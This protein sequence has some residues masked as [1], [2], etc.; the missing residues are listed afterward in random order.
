MDLILWRHAYA[1]YTLPDMD[2]ALNA[3]GHK[4]AAKMA[5]WLNARLAENCKILVSPARRAIETADALERKYKILPDLAPD[6]SAKQILQAVNW[7]HAKETVLVVG[8]QPALGQLC[9][10]LVFGL[11]QDFEIR[12]SYIVWISQRERESSLQ[13]YIKAMLGP[14]LAKKA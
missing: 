11:E 8:H 3:K 10:S 2:R 5:H 4:Q 14:E 6:A 1:D 12:K 7:P 9:A 13:T